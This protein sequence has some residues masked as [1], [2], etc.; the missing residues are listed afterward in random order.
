MNIASSPILLRLQRCSEEKFTG[1]LSISSLQGNSLS[2]LHGECWNFI[3]F[4][5]HLVGNTLGIHPARRMM[6]QFQQQKIELSPVMKRSLGMALKTPD[7]PH[8]LLHDG[9]QTHG[10]RTEQIAKIIDGSLQ[11]S[12]FDVLRYE[13]LQQQS[14]PSLTYTLENH[15]FPEQFVPLIAIKIKPLWAT[16]SDRF[17]GWKRQGLMSYCPHLSAQIADYGQ[18]KNLLPGGTYKSFLE[19]LAQDLTLWDI[20][21]HLAEDVAEVAMLLVDYQAQGAIELCPVGDIDLDDQRVADETISEFLISSEVPTRPV[22]THVSADLTKQNALRA[23]VEQVDCAYIP[24]RD[25]SQAL[26]SC[27]RHSPVALLVD[28]GEYQD[29][30]ALCEQLR[31]TGKFKHIPIVLLGNRQGITGRLRAMTNR[32]ITHWSQLPDAQQLHQFLIS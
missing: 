16:V 1:Q 19:L 7:L 9:V 10:L 18:L 2:E 27:L 20:A 12:L 15:R 29:G 21:A 17:K 23:V 30:Y 22:I 4:R 5:G 8:W 25:F 24:V 13:I 3:F 6:R 11:E 26:V 32:T 31:S 14:G 28:D